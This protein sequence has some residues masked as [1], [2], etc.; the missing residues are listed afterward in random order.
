MGKIG[1]IEMHFTYSS[2]FWNLY[3]GY[4]LDWWFVA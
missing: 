1:N 3:F 4:R 2:V